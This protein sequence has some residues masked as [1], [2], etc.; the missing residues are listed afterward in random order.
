MPNYWAI[1][2]SIEDFQEANI[3]S[4]RILKNNKLG[5]FLETSDANTGAHVRETVC[6]E[7][8]LYPDMTV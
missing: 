6:H 1:G 8:R 2:L 4:R 5:M 3:T 7:T